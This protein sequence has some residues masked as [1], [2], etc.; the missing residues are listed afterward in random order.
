VLSTS[1]T[2]VHLAGALGVET[3]VMLPINYDMR[4]GKPERDK[5]LWYPTVKLL[6]SDKPE[7]WQPTLDKVIEGLLTYEKS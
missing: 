4:W 2:A 7:N 6:K 1:N 5:A 3:W